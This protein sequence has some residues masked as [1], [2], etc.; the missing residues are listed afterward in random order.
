MVIG[1]ITNSGCDLESWG[2][3][4]EGREIGNFMGWM[5]LGCEIA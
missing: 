1:Q 2:P 4:R 5:V 3:S